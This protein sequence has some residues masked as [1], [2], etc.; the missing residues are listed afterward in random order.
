[1]HEL[2]RHLYSVAQLANGHATSFH[3]GDWAS[4]AGRWHDLGKY[5]REFQGYIRSASGY[6][7]E[8]HI[9]TA[10]GRV[11]HSTAGAIHAVNQWG[12]YGRVLA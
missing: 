5:S 1:M 3:A 4:V 7:P 11:D 2:K 8:A 10:P 6:N 12:V 9:E